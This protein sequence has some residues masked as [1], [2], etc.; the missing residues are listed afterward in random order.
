MTKPKSY[1]LKRAAVRIAADA[2]HAVPPPRLYFAG[3]AVGKLRNVCS[4]A[5][6]CP[7]AFRAVAKILGRL[8]ETVPF[9]GSGPGMG[10]R[11]GRDDGT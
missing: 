3:N 4:P 1:R 11:K 5:G 6:P 9:G 8:G 7:H 10:S 2:K